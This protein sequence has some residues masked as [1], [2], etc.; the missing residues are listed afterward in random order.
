MAIRN[1]A[2]RPPKMSMKIIDKLSDAIQHNTSVTD[3]CKYTGISRD[4]YYRYMNSNSVFAERMKDAKKNQN[5]VV[6]SF[7]TFCQET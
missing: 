6:F 5:K 3:A 4:T 1:A 2:G 7:L